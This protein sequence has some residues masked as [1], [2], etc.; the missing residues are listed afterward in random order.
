M[1]DRSLKHDLALELKAVTD[2]LGEVM[3]GLRIR[4]PRIEDLAVVEMPASVLAYML[5]DSGDDTQTL[6]DLNLGQ[7]PLL[8][9]G[10]VK[11][12]A[13]G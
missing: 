9:D 2:A 7:T 6:I 12:L 1:T 11:V 5:Y 13:D 8:F 10:E 4:L 3:A